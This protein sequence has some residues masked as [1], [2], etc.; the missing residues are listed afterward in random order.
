LLEE[1]GATADILET[2]SAIASASS[3]VRV[4]VPPIAPLTP[5]DMDAPP[6]MVI[7]FDPM[8]WIL[9]RICAVEPL[10]MDIRTIT[11]PTPIMMPSMVKKLRSL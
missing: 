6:R 2:C 11:E 9:E 5:P 1:E 3:I 10:P 7:K 4:W 8:L